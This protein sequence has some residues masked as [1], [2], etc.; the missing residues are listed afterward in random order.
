MSDDDNGE[1]IGKLLRGADHQAEYPKDLYTATRA[2][3]TT[4]VRMNKKD[5]CRKQGAMILLLIQLITIIVLI[6]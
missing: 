1:D 4:N 2:E 5:G 6:S 3:Y